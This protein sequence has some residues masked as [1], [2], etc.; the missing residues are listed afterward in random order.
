MT[1]EVTPIRRTQEPRSIASIYLDD[2]G[3]ALVDRVA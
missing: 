3:R 2:R 1:A